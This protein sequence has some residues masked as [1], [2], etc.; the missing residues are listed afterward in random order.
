M[1]NPIGKFMISPDIFI[2]SYDS[3][4]IFSCNGY[5]EFFENGDAVVTATDVNKNTIPRDNW[6]L[7]SAK[8]IMGNMWKIRLSRDSDTIDTLTTDLDIEKELMER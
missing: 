4:L 8:H 7:D 5:I 2:C 3:N 1:E 6:K